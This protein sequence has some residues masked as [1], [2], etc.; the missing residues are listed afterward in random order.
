MHKK[1][2]EI[3]TIKGAKL[4]YKDRVFNK[5]NPSGG[6]GPLLNPY[7]HEK[8]FYGWL[9]KECRCHLRDATC[10]FLES[11]RGV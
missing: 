2:E 1:L 10:A 5:F 6:F 11:G 8:F 4:H 3:E 7:L 9:R